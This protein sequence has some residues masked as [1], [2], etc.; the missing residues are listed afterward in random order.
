MS[1]LYDR[2]TLDLRKWLPARLVSSPSSALSVPSVLP[3]LKGYLFRDS[4]AGVMSTLGIFSY[5][6]LEVNYLLVT[7][8]MLNPLSHPLSIP[9]LIE[10]GEFREF[11]KKVKLVP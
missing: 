10:V 11:V 9:N 4:W 2:L 1:F 3:L 7:S 8:G 6:A 5:L